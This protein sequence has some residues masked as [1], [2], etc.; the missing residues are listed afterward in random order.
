MERVAGLVRELRAENHRIRYV[1]AGG[2]LGID[3]QHREA[4]EDDGFAARVTAY[5]SAVTVPLKGLNV[6]LLLEPGRVLVGPAGVLLARVLY[7][8]KNGG[9]QFIVTDAGMNDLLRPALYNAH[10]EIVPTSVSPRRRAGGEK[11]IDVVGPVCET[12]DFFA[13]DR[14]MAE[15]EA[16]ELLAV[17]DAGA[18]GMSLASNYNSRP[19][20]AEVMVDG[21]KATVV[22]R[23]EA[24]DDLLRGEG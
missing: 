8:K 14:K 19:R 16:G 24:M 13:R 23:R 7:R 18:Y 22:R 20:P 2:G 4:G 10:H 9:K 1:D 21:R 3:Y 6:H 5:A 17:L 12:G 11:I 15:P